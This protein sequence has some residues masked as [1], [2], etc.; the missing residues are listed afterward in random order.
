MVGAQLWRFEELRS[1]RVRGRALA[2]VPAGYWPSTM[3]AATPCAA[4]S[5]G[6]TGQVVFGDRAGPVV[7]PPHVS[8]QALHGSNG[9]HETDIVPR[10]R[11]SDRSQRQA[12]EMTMAV[13]AGSA[14]FIAIV[15]CAVVFGTILRVGSPRWW[16]SVAAPGLA[17]TMLMS[18]GITIWMLL[19]ARGRGL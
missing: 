10:H 2:A 5:S 4:P 19:R 12:I 15:T 16:D 18:I 11:F 14:F 8:A 1:Q 6:P 7:Y 9:Q 17:V 3:T 13:V